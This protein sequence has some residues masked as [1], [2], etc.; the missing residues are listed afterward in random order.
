MRIII[1]I[2]AWIS[3]T[4]LTLKGTE[5]TNLSLRMSVFLIA[6]LEIEKEMVD[7]NTLVFVFLNKSFKYL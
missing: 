2:L 1:I 7:Y 5:W 6:E 3:W 4:F